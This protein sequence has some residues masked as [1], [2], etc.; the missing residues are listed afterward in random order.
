MYCEVDIFADGKLVAC[1]ASYC[2][3]AIMRD[4]L[5]AKVEADDQKGL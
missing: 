2:S 1:W 4:I 5:S 3:Q